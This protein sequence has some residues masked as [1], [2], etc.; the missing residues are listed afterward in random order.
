MM[1]S[2]HRVLFLTEGQVG[3]SL[4]LTPAL[5]AVKRTFPSCFVAVLVVERYTPLDDDVP[6]FGVLKAT[7][8]QRARR[9]LGSNPHVDE[10]LI[11]SRNRLRALRGVK[12]MAAELAIVRTIRRFRFDTVISTWPEDRFSLWAF[13]S[14]ASQRVGQRNTAFHFLLTHAPKIEKADRGILEYY[15]ALAEEIGARI[16]SR[17]T[18]LNV[19]EPDRQRARAFL[20]KHGI[21]DS[22]PFVV[23]QPGATADYKIWPPERFAAI[24]DY[25]MFERNIPV[26]LCEG[27][28]DHAIAEEIVRR[29]ARVP[30]RFAG[31]A[32]ALIEAA[33]LCISNDSGP[34]HIAVAVQTPSLAFFRIAQEKEWGVYA[35]G[36]TRV[37]LRTAGKC[38]ACPADKCND[39][40]PAGERYGTYCMRMISLEVAR[41][42]VRDMLARLEL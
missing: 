37:S 13:L 32:A 22:Q 35:D 14:G 19:A 26:V 18:E 28:L 2:P 4:V 6:A 27:P 31:D 38:S 11:V 24:I 12:R 1:A 41:A 39:L 3:D 17:E 5:R 25:V 8:E 15:C 33:R 10:F 16:E 40:V 20:Q 36:P 21:G 34:R 9:V 7:P 29:V 42:T 23:V 30:T